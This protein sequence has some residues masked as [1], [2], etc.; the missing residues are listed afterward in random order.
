MQLR[1]QLYVPR[2]FETRLTHDPAPNAQVGNA[3]GRIHNSITYSFN[4][5]RNTIPKWV[6]II[7]ESD[8]ISNINYSQFGVSGAYGMVIE[9]SMK[10]VNNLVNSFLGQNL[11]Q[12][13]NKYNWPNILWIEPTLHSRYQD[14]S[15]RI[16]FIRSLHIAVQN[17]NRMV[18]LPLRQHW[19][20]HDDS[21]VSSGRLNQNGY[22]TYC[23]AMDSTIRFADTKLMRNHGVPMHQ[24]FQK[25]KI[26]EDS[27]SRIYAFEK[28]VQGNASTFERRTMLRQEQDNQQYQQMRRFYNDRRPDIQA[29]GNVPRPNQERGGCPNH[30]RRPTNSCKRQLFK[31]Q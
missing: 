11:P 2:N 22:N 27:D 28:M 16:K 6:V 31:K 19:N 30:R 14:N 5:N 12:K 23:S 25:D 1:S 21:L 4:M 10:Q 9:Y 18:V 20:D 3:I 24:I 13:A 15:L 17:Y 29:A 8:V 7:T 26:K